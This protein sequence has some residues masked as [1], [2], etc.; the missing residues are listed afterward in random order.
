MSAAGTDAAQAAAG[1]A[2]M[3]VTHVYHSGFAVE[4]PGCNLVFDWYTGALPPLARDLPLVVFVS[5]SHYDHYDA[6]IWRLAE[7]F[8]KVTYV[9]D[10]SV[11]PHAPA[12][13]DVHAVRPDQELSLALPAS[14]EYPVELRV[15]TLESNDEG[16]AFL[17]RAQE[18]TL[19]FSG[20][21]NSWQWDREAEKNEASDEFFRRELRRASA[22]WQRPHVDAAF[23][24]VDPRLTNPVAGLVA[25]MEEL[26]AN[27]VFPMHYWDNRQQAQDAVARDPR[28]ARYAS[29]LVWDDSWQS[30]EG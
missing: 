16:V 20:D 19:Y 5:H 3:R 30:T 1:A 9:V 6:H 10:E 4:L 8:P 27:V 7:D 15:R 17:V 23:V 26:G 11:A 22:A 18:R 2:P 21:L 28:A 14:A 24:P 13:L 25:Y 29:R 12:G